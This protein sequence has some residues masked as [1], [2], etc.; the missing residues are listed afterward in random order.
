MII[1]TQLGYFVWVKMREKIAEIKE[2][3]GKGIKE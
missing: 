3:N 2:E 1:V